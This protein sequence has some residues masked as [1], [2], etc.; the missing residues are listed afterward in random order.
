MKKKRKKALT[1]I[2]MMVV[3]VLIG[4]IGSVV[5]YN[6][7]GGLKKGKVFQTKQAAQML[8]DILSIEIE[9]PSDLKNFKDGKVKFLKKTQLT[10]DPKKLLYDAWGSEFDVNFKDGDLV[11]TS[12]HLQANGKVQPPS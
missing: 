6:V 2:E 5:A 10:K 11:V 1:L 4:I 9:D 7:S 3:I 12:E 8:K